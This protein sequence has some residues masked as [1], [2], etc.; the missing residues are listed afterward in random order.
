MRTTDILLRCLAIQGRIHVYR[1]YVAQTPSRP[2]VIY[3][4]VS[5]TQGATIQYNLTMS[6]QMVC[7]RQNKQEY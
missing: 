1:Y 7:L 6:F 3:M 5:I 4:T 2:T